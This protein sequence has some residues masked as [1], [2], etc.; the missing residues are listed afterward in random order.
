MQQKK[1]KTMCKRCK[2]LGRIIVEDWDYPIP[3]SYWADC[4]ECNNNDKN[5]YKRWKRRNPEIKK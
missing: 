3:G 5:K 2:G 1:N 4:L